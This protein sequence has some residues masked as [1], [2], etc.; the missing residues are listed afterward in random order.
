MIEPEIKSEYNSTERAPR[1]RRPHGARIAVIVVLVLLIAGAISLARRLV[2]RKA[3]AAETEKLALPT[4]YVLKPAAEPANDELTLP[5]ALQAYVESAIYSRT[6][7]YLQRWY[8]DIGSHVKKGE[9]LA[10]IDAPEVD[11]ELYQARA[12]RQQIQAQVDLAKTSAERWLNLRKSDSVSQQEVDQQTSGYTQARANLAAA[13]ANVRRLEQ[14]ESFKHIDAPFSGVITR[15]NIDV[16]ALINAGSGQTKELFDLAQLDPLRVY[17]S[18][19]QS[20]APSIKQGM[21]AYLQLAEFPGQ[22]F[23]GKVV[24]TADAIDP[25]T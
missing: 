8:K 16:G 9:R 2:E 22:K 17:V 15:R 25:A 5:G 12:A 10:D 20:Y 18:V 7:G 6:N 24:R 3:L 11:Q 14:L 1:Q 21:K 23:A 13:D 19:P 4:V